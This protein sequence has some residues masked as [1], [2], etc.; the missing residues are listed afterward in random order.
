M[1]LSYFKC[2]LPTSDLLPWTSTISRSSQRISRGCIPWGGPEEVWRDGKSEFSPY[3]TSTPLSIQPAGV[4][5][6]LLCAGNAKIHGDTQGY[7]CYERNSLEFHFQGI[8][9]MI[10]S[11]LPKVRPYSGSPQRCGT[12]GLSVLG[13]GWSSS[14]CEARKDNSLPNIPVSSCYF[15]LEGMFLL[16]PVLWCW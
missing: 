1:D 9:G 8:L 4:H 14:F 3:K 11:L 6:M 2:W 7:F 13:R 5:R 12:L 10:R 15:S 16:L